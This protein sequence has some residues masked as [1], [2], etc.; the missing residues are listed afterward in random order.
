[1]RQRRLGGCIW[2]GKQQLFVSLQTLGTSKEAEAP[3]WPCVRMWQGSGG[4]GAC[5]KMAPGPPFYGQVG[6]EALLG[7]SGQERLPRGAEL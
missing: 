7:L 2:K 4:L 5:Y 6:A 3:H 1:M